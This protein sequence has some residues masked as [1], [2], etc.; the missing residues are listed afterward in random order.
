MAVELIRRSAGRLDPQRLHRFVTAF[1]SV[2]PLTMGELWAWPSAL[3]SALVEQLRAR[4]D[5]LADEPRP[6]AGRRSARRRA[7]EASRAKDAWPAQVHPAFVIRLLERSREVRR[8]RGRAAAPARRGA[9]RRGPD[10]RGRDSIR[11][12][13]SGGG[14]GVHVEPDRQPAARSRPST[15]AS[16]SRASAWSSRCFSAIRP[17]STAGWTSAAAIGIGTRS[18]KWRSRPAKGSCAWRSRASSARARW[19][20]R[21]PTIA[22]AHVGYYLIGGG[23][24]QFEKGIGVVARASGCASAGCSSGTRR[25]ATSAR[26]RGN[27]AAGGGR[28][29]LCLFARVARARCW[30]GSRC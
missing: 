7:R 8:R 28:A 11:G 14:A 12:A 6:S 15:G 3:K 27:G 24:R 30:S 13:A 26:S 20:N 25:L 22:G 1:Q 29:R 21:R 2:T 10:D 16:S 17:A 5:V 18:R 4:A 23:R 9:G 19:P